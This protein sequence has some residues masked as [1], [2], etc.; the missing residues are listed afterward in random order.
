M[1]IE[2]LKQL[3]NKIIEAFDEG[4]VPVNTSLQLR[5]CGCSLL[6][7]NIEGLILLTWLNKGEKVVEIV[8]STGIEWNLVYLDSFPGTNDIKRIAFRHLCDHCKENYLLDNSI[9]MSSK[10]YQ[11]RGIRE[12]ING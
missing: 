5:S 1:M 3:N 10:V 6:T 11:E 4:G 9:G 7:F 12:E 8:D 2:K